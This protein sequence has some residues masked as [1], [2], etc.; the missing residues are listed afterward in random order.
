MNLYR[1]HNPTI[2]RSADSISCDNKRHPC[3]IWVRGTAPDGVYVE[4]S[5]KALTGKITRDWAKAS[6]IIREWENNGKAP[7]VAARPAVEE[8]KESFLALATSVVSQK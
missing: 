3:P 8:W 5:L 1:R 2:C 4:R 7:K 6:E